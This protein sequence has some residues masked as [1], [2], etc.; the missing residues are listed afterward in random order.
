M[1]RPD[2]W[3]T[4]DDSTAFVFACPPPPRATGSVP[5]GMTAPVECQLEPEPEQSCSASVESIAPLV[6]SSNMSNETHQSDSR[7]GTDAIGENFGT[8]RRNDIAT[9][10]DAATSAT[11]GAIPGLQVAEMASIEGG[12]PY[13]D[14]N[15]LQSKRIEITLPGGKV[16]GHTFTFKKRKPKLKKMKVKSS[17]D[18]FLGS[19]ALGEKCIIM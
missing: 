14:A 9:G 13:V 12:Q 1:A 15:S 2:S 3:G 10:Q 19:K 16:I 6:D 18:R 4:G 5:L 7:N 8:P 11:A 17:E